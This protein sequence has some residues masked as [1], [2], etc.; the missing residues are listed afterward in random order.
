VTI[1]KKG[2]HISSNAQFSGRLVTKHTSLSQLQSHTSQPPTVTDVT[3]S[4]KG[5]YISSGAHFSGL[6]EY[7]SPIIYGS[8]S[9]RKRQNTRKMQC[10]WNIFFQKCT[11]DL[12]MQNHLAIQNM[13]DSWCIIPPLLGSNHNSHKRSL[14]HILLNKEYHVTSSLLMPRHFFIQWYNFQKRKLS[15]FSTISPY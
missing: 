5:N 10:C 15:P 12:I 14:I 3:I 7:S 8:P 11:F 4:K 2:N 1:S 9:L 6:P 13:L